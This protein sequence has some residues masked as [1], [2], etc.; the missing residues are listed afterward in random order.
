MSD[1]LS[2]ELLTPNDLNTEESVPLWDVK[3]VARF[4]KYNPSTVRSMARNKE[5][6]AFKV[7]REW[8]F[9]QSDVIAFLNSL[10]K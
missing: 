4:L 2:G 10:K 5:L 6:P 7:G 9:V 3:D 8:R 1:T